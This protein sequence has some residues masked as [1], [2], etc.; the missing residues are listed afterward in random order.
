MGTGG[1]APLAKDEQ[2]LVPEHGQ[3]VGAA[4]VGVGD[5]DKV[6]DERVE[7]LVRQRVLLVEQDADE[8]RG[9]ACVQ[10]EMGWS[11]LDGGAEART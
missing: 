6:E 10:C 1:H 2:R 9:C 11:A 8:K 7:D 4:L 3:R 5:T